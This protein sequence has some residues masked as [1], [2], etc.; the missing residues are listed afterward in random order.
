MKSQH[1]LLRQQ[2]VERFS[3]ENTIVPYQDPQTNTKVTV[4]TKEQQRA[5]AKRKGVIKVNLE[6]K[7]THLDQ[8]PLI[9]NPVK[10]WDQ[11]I[12]D[13]INESGQQAKLPEFAI[14]PFGNIR[15]C[16]KNILNQ[17][18][19]QVYRTASE[20]NGWIV[21]NGLSDNSQDGQTKTMAGLISESVRLYKDSVRNPAFTVALVDYHLARSAQKAVD[22][23]ENNR[24]LMWFEWPKRPNDNRRKDGLQTMVR[25]ASQFIF[26]DPDI[27]SHL[28]ENPMMRAFEGA[29]DDSTPIYIP[30]LRILLRG[31]WD[32]TEELLKDWEVIYTERPTIIVGDSG[33]LS[34]YLRD[35]LTDT[36]IQTLNEKTEKYSSLSE[37]K[38]YNDLLTEDQLN[39]EDEDEIQRFQAEVQTRLGFISR[40]YDEKKIF[41]WHVDEEQLSEIL[42]KSLHENDKNTKTKVSQIALLNLA[43]YLGCTDEATELF[44]SD[45]FDKRS[46]ATALMKALC[47][48]KERVLF[49]QEKNF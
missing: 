44:D 37:M 11:L 30:S 45:I 5:D 25:Y 4:K 15:G 39:C 47:L 7:D 43:L 38:Q 3:M 29:T 18:K 9:I 10:G 27:H 20:G 35:F 34:E 21:H 48:G 42:V 41:F 17:F 40:F 12:R 1:K 14:Y 13:Y 28:L 22:E 19:K 33:G 8:V 23:L 16:P 31:S 46:L 6:F 36:K 49:S 24:D 32:D 26:Y 2:R